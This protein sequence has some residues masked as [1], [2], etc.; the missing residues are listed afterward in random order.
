[1]LNKIYFISAVTDFEL[2]NRLV[3]QNEFV[4]NNK[5]IERVSFDNSRDNQF[6]SKRYNQFLN[7]YD[8]SQEAWFVFCHSD[9]EIKE[10]IAEKLN[11]LDVNKIYGPTGSKLLFEE[12]YYF[13]EGRGQIYSKRRNG[14][15]ERY[16]IS[17]KFEDAYEVD[18]L[19]CQAVIIHSSLVKS[20]G[21]RFDEHLEYD[22]YVEDFCISALLNH[23]IET[24][25]CKIKC[26][27]WSDAGYISF[28]PRYNNMLKYVNKKYPNHAFGGTVSVIGGKEITILSPQERLLK[29][30]RKNIR[31]NLINDGK[32]Y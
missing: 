31:Q 4:K 3:C 8:Y 27:H 16:P 30:L 13:R 18:T 11:S 21:L 32:K 19:D 26:C 9:W 22:L 5:Q 14:S 6:I 29:Q 2:Y 1:M 12:G 10:D 25:I 20:Y 24:N 28:H 23:G 15:D 17:E 7:N